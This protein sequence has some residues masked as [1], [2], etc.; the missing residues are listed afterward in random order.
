MKW[1]SILAKRKNSIRYLLNKQIY[2]Y[3]QRM[4]TP[5][6]P[7]PI[8]LMLEVTNHCQLRCI[9]CPRESSMGKEL[10]IGHMKPE[11][12]KKIVEKNYIYLDQLNLSG[13]G[14]SLLYPHLVDVINYINKI[15]PCISI[16]ISTNACIPTAP[17]IIGEITDKI[18]ALNI[19][20]DGCGDVFERIRRG[21][22][23]DQFLHNLTEIS[24]ITRN[25]R[26]E[27]QLNIVV[28]KE[29]YHQIPDVINLAKEMG[30]NRV[31]FTPINLVGIDWDIYYYNFFNSQAY[32]EKLKEAQDT[33]K[34]VGIELVR[35]GPGQIRGFSQCIYP[36]SDFYITWDGFLVPCCAKPFPNE[37]N[38][39]NVFE[40][41]LMKCL[42]SRD[43]IEF[44]ILSKKNITPEF[45]RRCHWVRG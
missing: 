8:S 32:K 7:R 44:R 43:S 28:V 17:K 10:A 26:V 20:A 2:L 37:K 29:N 31:L 30:F 27:V 12:L 41:G 38:F 1:L 16:F 23:Y 6:L 13:Q 14:E 39:G 15:K 21:A 11:N 25:K 18:A 40:H 5:R 24:R 33:A 3:R 22:T 9:T 36:W 45:C 35:N 4:R 42:N 19:S 34:R